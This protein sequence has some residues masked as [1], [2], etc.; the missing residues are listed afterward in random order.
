MKENRSRKLG[1]IT[2]ALGLVFI[3]VIS[4]VMVVFSKE[5]TGKPITIV[6][7]TVDPKGGS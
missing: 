1:V 2:F 7:S 6:F 5:A 3:L 4:S